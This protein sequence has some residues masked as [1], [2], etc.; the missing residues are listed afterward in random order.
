MADFFIR[1]IKKDNQTQIE[2]LWDRGKNTPLPAPTIA[3]EERDRRIVTILRKYLDMEFKSGQINVFDRKDFEAL[4]ELLFDLI[5]QDKR[6]FIEFN[7]WHN[8]ALDDDDKANGYNIFLEFD[9]INEFDDLAILPWEYIY[10]S[11]QKKGIKLLEP[12]LAASPA[13]KINFY[14]KFPLL[15]HDA[16]DKEIFE[17]KPPLRILLIISNPDAELE[18]TT[19]DDLLQYFRELSERVPQ[20]EIRYLYQPDHKNFRN[21]LNNGNGQKP[22]KYFLNDKLGVK[23]GKHNSTFSPDILHF[24]GHG[25]VEENHGA[26]YFAEENKYSQNF[27]KVSKS[28]EWFSEC[29]KNSRLKPKMVFLQICNGARIVDYDDN[30]GTAICLLANRVPFVI[31]MQNPILENHALQFTK[32]F[33]DNFSEGKDIGA[34]VT[35]G[36]YDLGTQR[37]F[38]EKAFGSPVLFTYVHY[39]LK[40]KFEDNE[41]QADET[42]SEEAIKVCMTP[43]CPYYGNEKRY[44]FKDSYCS[45]GHMLTT[46]K[47]KLHAETSA[48]RT[49]RFGVKT[50]DI[51]QSYNDPAISQNMAQPES[52]YQ[53]SS[54]NG[55]PVRRSG[56]WS[57]TLFTLKG[58]IHIKIDGDISNALKWLESCLASKTTIDKLNNIENFYSA[59]KNIGITPAIENQIKTTLHE[60]A[61]ELKETD[62]KPEYL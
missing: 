1:F 51:N 26:L 62:I 54:G 37:E 56:Q 22:E 27:E 13:K 19:L 41:E 10:F 49:S 39:P 12:F 24:A 61:D 46:K 11:K 38:K 47:R 29:L 20:M 3:A 28:D 16:F 14:R 36:R 32:V 33:Y 30:R 8:S 31:A 2:Y 55:A 40:M 5:F 35:M 43:G 4:G 48:V 18:L 53:R 44:S 58:E 25:S 34:C 42:A 23:I 6:L 57:S 9:Q 17:I 45:Q 7:D 15:V 52:A 60:F 21:E 50:P 59:S